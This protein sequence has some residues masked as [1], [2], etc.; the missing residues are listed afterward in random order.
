MQPDISVVIPARN[1]GPRLAA[2]IDSIASARSTRARVE[3][4]IADDESDDDTEGHLSAAWPDLSRHERLEVHVSRMPERGGVPRTRNHAA[5]L[6]S[7]D[8]LF[9]T[10]AHVR[11]PAGWDEL[12]YRHVRPNRVVAGV[13]TEDKTRFAGYGCRLVVPFMGTYWNKTPVMAPV[14][15][16]V[17]ACPATVLPRELF[18]KL[19]GYDD[20]LLMY[21]SAEPEFSVRAWLSGAEIIVV[22]QLTVA[23]RFKPPQERLAFVRDMRPYMV[24]NGLRFGL[25]YTDEP[26]ALQL[27]RYYSLKFP[28]LFRDALAAVQHSDVWERR[29]QLRTQLPR[30]FSWFTGHFNLKDQAD[31]DLL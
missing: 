25:L 21:G 24:R 13:V 17:A 10:D 2:T 11:F 12:V 3:V 27:L 1:E 30:D 20:G 16:Q 31:G 19:G 4:I 18:R 7:A 22:P 14:E 6:A 9:M 29:E 15:V 26:A 23:H 28:N 8:I 5:A